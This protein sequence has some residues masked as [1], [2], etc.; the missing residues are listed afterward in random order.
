[1]TYVIQLMDGGAPTFWSNS[2]KYHPS[3]NW[4]D[5]HDALIF[6]QYSDAQSYINT[7][8]Q[9]QAEQCKVVPFN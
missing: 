5:K 6:A 4:G 1:M 2:K 7:N 8:L 3:G 9:H